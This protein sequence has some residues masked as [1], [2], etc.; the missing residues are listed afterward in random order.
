MRDQV[1]PSRRLRTVLEALITAVSAVVVGGGGFLG[2]VLVVAGGMSDPAPD[3]TPDQYGPYWP[4]V[5]TGLTVMALS[6][7]AAVW[8]SAL[9]ARG[10]RRLGLIG[11]GSVALLFVLGLLIFGV[12][13]RFG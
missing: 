4:E 9:A 11:L 2:F 8:F 5:L 10:R 3:A 13:V 1:D 6:L 7:G 12:L